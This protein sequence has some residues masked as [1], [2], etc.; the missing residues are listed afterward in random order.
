MF[1][2]IAD[3]AECTQETIPGSQHSPT[4]NTTVMQTKGFP[5]GLVGT[6][7]NSLEGCD[8]SRLQQ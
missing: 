5:T 2:D 8:I 1:S 7:N 4:G 6:L 3:V